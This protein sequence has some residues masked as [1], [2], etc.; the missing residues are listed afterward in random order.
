MQ[1]KPRKTN[2]LRSLRAYSKQSSY[3]NDSGDEKIDFH[4][5]DAAL[6]SKHPTLVIVIIRQ[7]FFTS[8]DMIIIT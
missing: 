4:V 5:L 6:R 3:G 1:N 8:T 2:S 7:T